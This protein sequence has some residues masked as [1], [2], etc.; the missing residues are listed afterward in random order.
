VRS[1]I[2]DG[3]CRFVPTA[4]E[5]GTS[6]LRTARL[7]NLNLTTFYIVRRVIWIVSG[8]DPVP[9][10]LIDQLC[11]CKIFTAEK[12]TKIYRKAVFMEV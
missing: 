9:C 11:K 1:D 10:I 12:Y 5:A 4:F 7:Y 3:S 2:W 6:C 8:L